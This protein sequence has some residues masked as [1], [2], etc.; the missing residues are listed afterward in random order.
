MRGGFNNLNVTYELSG[1]AGISPTTV[2][3]VEGSVITLA[4]TPVRAGYEFEGWQLGATRYNASSAYTVTT[5]VTFTAVWSAKL[6]FYS[7]DLNGG[8][9][10]VPASGSVASGSQFTTAPT[11]TRASVTVGDIVTYYTFTGWKINNSG[12]SL[13]AGVLTTMPGSDSPVVIYAQWSA[14]SYNLNGGV[15]P[16]P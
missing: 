3:T 2:S 9:S 13:A 16:T 6:V 12:S 7:Y 4:G 8:T 11:P 5:S 14:M 1:G 10:T 15:M